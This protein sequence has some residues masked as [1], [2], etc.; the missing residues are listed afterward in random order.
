MITYVAEANYKGT[1]QFTYIVTDTGGLTAKAAVTI[2][3]EAAVPGE[4][5]KAYLYLPAMRRGQ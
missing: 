3:I 1:D 4:N 2:E 5:Y